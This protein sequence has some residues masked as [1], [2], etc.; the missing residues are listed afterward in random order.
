VRKIR[1]KASAIIIIFNLFL[2]ILYAVFEFKPPAARPISMGGAFVGVSDD[3]NAIDYNPAGLRHISGFQFSSTYSN[4]YSVD[5]LNYS[6]VKFAFPFYGF[7]NIGVLYSNF[8]PPE[9]QEQ[10]FIISH[11]FKFE[12]RMLFG[13]NLK[14]MSVKIKEYGGDST[15]GLDIGI[16]AKISEYFSVGTFAKNVNEPEISKG[17]EKLIETFSTGFFYKSLKDLNFALDFEKISD[18]PVI[19]HM[20][21]EFNL[22]KFFILRSGIQINPSNYTFGFGINYKNIIFDYGYSSHP[23]LEA[24]HILSLSVKF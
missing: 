14:S 21:A 15:F 11:G 19:T 1:F 22:F 20:G 13:Y 2:N 9:Y 3:V 16:L 10:I 8:G 23:T 4:I 18:K 6:E 24:M 7:G 17:H 12:D 5:G